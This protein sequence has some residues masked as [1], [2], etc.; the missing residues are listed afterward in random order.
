MTFPS[1][2]SEGNS[3]LYFRFF[4]SYC[5]IDMRTDLLG[6]YLRILRAYQEPKLLGQ[7]GN[8][9]VTAHYLLQ[10]LPKLKRVSKYRFILVYIL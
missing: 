10:L 5:C 3:K 7:T 1:C 4:V 2:K 9:M 6:L 8:F